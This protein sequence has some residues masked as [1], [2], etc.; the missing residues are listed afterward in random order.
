MLREAPAVRKALF[1]A[2]LLCAVVSAQALSLTAEYHHHQS[3]KDCCWLCHLGP[4]L[5][6]QPV[7]AP[8]A[9][10]EL[11]VAWMERCGECGAPHDLQTGSGS[12][13]APPGLG[14]PIY[15]PAP[16]HCQAGIYPFQ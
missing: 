2:L 9:G 5:F 1:V 4:F 14:H 8:T 15:H 13:R 6:L 3:V 7:A 12:S 11:H 16:W 10:P